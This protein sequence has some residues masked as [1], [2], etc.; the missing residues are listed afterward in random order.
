MYKRWCHS[1]ER[2]KWLDLSRSNKLI[3]YLCK[4][5]QN[6]HNK[7]S[8]ETWILTKHWKQTLKR[9]QTFIN[10]C[11]MHSYSL[12][13]MVW[14]LT[15]LTTTLS[16]R[17][18]QLPG[19]REIKKKMEMDWSHTLRNSHPCCTSKGREEE[20]SLEMPDGKTL[21]WTPR[22]WATPYKKQEP[23]ENLCRWPV[24]WPSKF[25]GLST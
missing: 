25:R 19:E 18:K 13:E 3:Q 22:R 14:Q 7:C 10:R 16:G 21:K 6:Y 2:E 17:A 8:S 4:T 12:F 1:L 20:D 9:T 23:V 11:L 15:R 24:W 5:Q